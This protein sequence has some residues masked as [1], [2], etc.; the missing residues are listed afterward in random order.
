MC[1]ISSE[2]D[3]D[4]VVPRRSV[5]DKMARSWQRLWKDMGDAI[6]VVA[7]R[8]PRLSPSQPKITKVRI[9]KGKYPLPEDRAGMKKIRVMVKVNQAPSHGTD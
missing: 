2:G 6:H 7:A 1:L 3:Y 9:V 8:D 5:E 4:Q